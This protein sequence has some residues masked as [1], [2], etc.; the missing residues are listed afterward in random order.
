MPRIHSVLAFLFLLTTVFPG[1]LTAQTPVTPESAIETSRFLASADGDVVVISPDRKRYAFAL[2]TGDMK[3]DGNWL[4]IMSGP[5]KELETAHPQPIARLFGR[6]LGERGSVMRTFLT[7]S[8]HMEWLDNRRLGFFWEDENNRIQFFTADVATKETKQITNHPTS[9]NF[10]T[11]GLNADRTLVYAALA[12]DELSRDVAFQKSVLDG[13][14]VTQ[15]DVRA[16]AE[17][18]PEG[19]G[20]L[21][22]WWGYEWFIGRKGKPAEKIE[23]GNREKTM[24]IPA[25]LAM[26]PEGPYAVV[27]GFPQDI[28]SEW[29]HY[30]NPMIVSWV[31]KALLGNTKEFQVRLLN[32]LYVIN[33]ETKEVRPLWNALTFGFSAHF[34]WS[35][36]GNRLLVGPTFLPLDG[37]TEAGLSGGAIAEIEVRSGAFKA[38]PVRALNPD[39]LKS[40]RWISSS[41]IEVVTTAGSSVFQKKVDAWE[42]TSAI[43]PNQKNE[44]A[45]RIEERS[46][47]NTPPVL[48]AIDRTTGNERIV[49]DPNPGLTSRFKLGR[50]EKAQW[51][52]EGEEPLEGEL[53]YPADYQAGKRYPFVLQTDG[54]SDS[55]SLYGYPEAVGLGT[56]SGIFLAQ[57]LAGRNVGVLQIR[58]DNNLPQN[59]DADV[60]MKRYESAVDFLVESGLA[61]AERIGIQG[62]SRTGWRI[63]HSLVNS[64]FVF[65]AAIAA[66]NIEGGY[67][68]N[69]L[70]GPGTMEAENN[71]EPY[72]ANGLKA[73]LDRSI[74]FHAE[75]IRTPLLKISQSPGSVSMA[76]GPWELFDRLRRL[77]HPVELY[78]M[79]DSEEHGGHQP[80]NPR[81]V[82]AIQNRALD[83]W[84]FWLLD[85]EFSAPEKADQYQ[86]WRRL[87]EQ[88]EELRDTPRPP[89]LVWTAKPVEG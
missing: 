3:R 40:L 77:K 64:D 68:E 86:S 36:D 87:R 66:D 48:V 56:G 32:Q 52:V 25:I 83:W 28:L 5:L 15:A 4:T 22:R 38:I 27:G 16:L 42:K 50:V 18:V 12:D 61:D 75:R 78:I 76:F 26:P 70:F 33:L 85:E 6:S 13:F 57:L 35:P 69:V 51:R 71:G 60:Y 72:G 24:N 89:K 88:H 80:Q 79:P 82:A 67:V 14:A 63:Q 30:N 74:P 23:I 84:L 37:A 10:F 29:R 43:Q 7:T 34:D 65:A 41:K 55:F 31:E 21:D 19:E 54:G 62:F 44:T 2:I 39:D 47:L 11:V 9:L 8:S 1:G 53:Y 73:W 20:M 81:Q 17:G 46:D 58:E 59:E 45:I 49:F